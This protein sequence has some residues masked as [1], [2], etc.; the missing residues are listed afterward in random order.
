MQRFGY[1]N[2]RYLLDVP[3]RLTIGGA[4]DMT[5]CC[6]I[7]LDGASLHNPGF[8][9]PNARGCISFE[10]HDL[11]FDLN[12]RVA[13]C[14]SDLCGLKFLYQAEAQRDLVRELIARLASRHNTPDIV[15]LSIPAQVAICR[16]PAWPS[17]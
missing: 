8:V 15:A 5:R 4:I 6:N 1:R 7:G 9:R 10:Y 12:F 11:L 17:D 14:G 13:H 16:R 2:P 3:V